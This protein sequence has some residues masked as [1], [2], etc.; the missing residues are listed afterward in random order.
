MT[1]PANEATTLE[2]PIVVRGPVTG[3]AERLATFPI[4]LPAPAPTVTVSDTP[5]LTLTTSVAP[6]TSVAP[7]ERALGLDVFRAVLLLAMNFSF[8]I[9]DWGPFPAWMYHAQVPPSPTAAYVPIAGLTWQD[10]LFP[11]FV[12]AMAAAI[13][14]ALGARIAR[15][16]A[17]P[18]MIWASIQR[19]F[20]L[21][22]LALVIGQV[23]PYW[24]HDDTHRGN[25]VALIGFVA[26]F[27]FLV[28]PPKT[29]S[30]DRRRWFRRAAWAA[31]ALVLF[32]VPLM[33]GQS[34]SPS[35]R[36]DI[37]A[38]LA[39]TS[40]A[41]T[42]IWLFTRKSLRLRMA[43]AAAV[44]IGRTAAPHVGWF[45]DMW[46]ATPADWL[47]D[48]WYL[49]LLIIV[50]AG[51]TAGELLGRWMTTRADRA[52]P[53][54]STWRLATLATL[55]AAVVPVLLVGLYHRNYPAATTAGVIAL[56]AAMLLS[57]RH[58]GNEQERVLAQLYTWAAFWLVAGML[59]EPLEGG[60]K[61][62][63]Q[64]LSY[65]F[66]SAGVGLAGLATLLVLADVMRVAKR[67]FAVLSTIGQN[68]L[69]AYVVFFLCGEHLLWL[70]GL[71]KTFT[72]TWQEATI[73]STVLTAIV[74][75]VVWAATRKRLVWR[76]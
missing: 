47:Y 21:V 29:W 31:V 20:L 50:V 66:I 71:G 28:Q 42:I 54:W 12:F 35:R 67:P 18:S 62:D 57:V 30:E 1:H 61:K 52:E 63:P 60:I 9:P 37:L 16:V 46:Y 19:A 4:A 13:P 75:F 53:T 38:A 5:S 7:G 68:S 73:R 8:T 64:T 27:A 3:D 69:F 45:G 55:G 41:G 44:V 34:F 11:G 70:T 74:G 56:A 49:D 48:A 2:Q 36:D 39:F 43:V 40:V 10:L 25:V 72:A 26:C 22:V 65:L 32:G 14:I 51:T 59:V 76:T 15:G 6:A 23:N 24:T 33:Y 17:Y 58:A